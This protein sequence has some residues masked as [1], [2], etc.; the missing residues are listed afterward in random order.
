MGIF[1]KLIITPLLLYLGKRVTEASRFGGNKLYTDKYRASDDSNAA[2][3][4]LSAKETVVDDRSIINVKELKTRTLAIEGVANM[5]IGNLSMLL[6]EQDLSMPSKEQEEL[7]K[8]QEKLTMTLS[9]AATCT[10]GSNLSNCTVSL[11]EA[12]KLIVMGDL[13]NCKLEISPSACITVIGKI[14]KNTTVTS[15]EGS[16]ALQP[17][18]VPTVYFGALENEFHQ[19]ENIVF[20][21]NY[22]NLSMHPIDFNYI[23]YQ[24]IPGLFRYSLDTMASCCQT[25]K[26]LNST[27]NIE[28][29]RSYISAIPIVSR[30][31]SSPPEPVIRSA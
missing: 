25:A 20:K 16:K 19:A 15:K 27:I 18:H 30:F 8:E 29:I 14:S 23:I 12:S 26:N 21:Q 28:N 7:P 5:T 2:Y 22:I 4:E 24:G 17:H 11:G 3:L 13:I 31:V 9:M 1:S 6:K 10:I